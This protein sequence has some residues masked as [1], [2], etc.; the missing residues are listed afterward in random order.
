[1]NTDSSSDDVEFVP[2]FKPI[3]KEIKEEILLK[4]KQ[5]TKVPVL[6]DQYGISA[7]TIYTWLARTVCPPVSWAKYQQLRRENEERKRIIGMMALDL[8][9]EK[10]EG[11]LRVAKNK[12]LLADLLGLSRKQ[13]YYPRKK[14][15][16][17]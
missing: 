13:I 10:K 6:A 11:Y 8:E 15:M 16:Q 4:I 12:Q 1:M 9:K 14:E 5:G 2:M 7:K 17:D 3:A